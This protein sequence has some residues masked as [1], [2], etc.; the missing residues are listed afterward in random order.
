MGDWTLILIVFVKSLIYVMNRHTSRRIPIFQSAERALGSG[1]LE[2]GTDYCKVCGKY[3][4]GK[5]NLG[6]HKDSIKLK[7]LEGN[8]ASCN[9][10]QLVVV[11]L[12]EYQRRQ[13]PKL[14]LPSILGLRCHPGMFLEIKE[15]EQESVGKGSKRDVLSE[16]AL[17]IF[18]EPGE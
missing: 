15:C 10:C 4:L 13:C 5:E 8:I 3:N 9:I 17:E 18:V 16:A 14:D 2:N 6:W 1:D 7:E 12:R 11:C